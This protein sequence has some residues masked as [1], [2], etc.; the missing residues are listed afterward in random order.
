MRG[1]RLASVSYG[2]WTSRKPALSLVQREFGRKW[3]TYGL[4]HLADLG[5]ESQAKEIQ[6]GLKRVESFP[7]ET[8]EYGNGR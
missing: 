4:G 8:K 5:L 3:L 2:L 1:R 6:K 7:W